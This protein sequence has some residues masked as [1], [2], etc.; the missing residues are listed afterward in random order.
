MKDGLMRRIIAPICV[1]TLSCALLVGCTSTSKALGLKKEAPNE[2]NI[3]TKAPLVVPPEY[4]LRP[5]K[6]GESSAENNYSQKAAREALIGNIDAAEPTRGEVILMTKA[7]VNRANQE[8]RLEIDG[9]NS[10]ERKSDS[11]TNRILFWQDGRM[12][13]QDGNVLPLD[14]EAEAKRLK[15][16]QSATG[17]GEVEITRRP[18]GP[19]LPGL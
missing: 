5:P 6:I 8:I 17:G 9:Q 16:V 3:L 14:P 12:V 18:G 1:L 10:V 15:S 2:F 7:G 13:D 4:N 11:L 19:K